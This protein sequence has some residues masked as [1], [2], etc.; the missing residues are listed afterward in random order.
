M[1]AGFGIA[2]ARTVTMS[3]AGSQFNMGVRPEMGGAS[4]NF[5]KIYK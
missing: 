4:L 2:S 5:T 3:V 1:G